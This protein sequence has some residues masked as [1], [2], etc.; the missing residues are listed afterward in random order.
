M[1][2]T[3]GGLAGIPYYDRNAS[4]IAETDTDS[5]Q[6]PSVTVSY[7]VPAGKRAIIYAMGGSHYTLGG[8]TGAS[9]QMT[10]VPKYTPVGGTGVFLKPEASG[11]TAGKLEVVTNIDFQLYLIEG[12]KVE[13]QVST[14]NATAGTD[15]VDGYING[16]E[17]DA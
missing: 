10:V 11:S 7:T 13:V 9:L 3:P 15:R 17:F 14:L 12:D 1:R 5:G 4:P 8:M 2:N 6:N 16:V